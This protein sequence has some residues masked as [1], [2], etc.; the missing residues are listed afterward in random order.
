MKHRFLKY[1]LVALALVAVV[2]NVDAKEKKSNNDAQNR[3]VGSQYGDYGELYARH[4][5]TV[6]R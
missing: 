2:S 6:C 3:E 4:I 1:T 5:D